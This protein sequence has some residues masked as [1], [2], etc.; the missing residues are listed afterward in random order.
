MSDENFIG[1]Q[2]KALHKL[3]AAFPPALSV[4]GH[5]FINRRFFSPTVAEQAQVGISLKTR[6]F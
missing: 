2:C 3:K 4:L 1:V 5:R 6:N